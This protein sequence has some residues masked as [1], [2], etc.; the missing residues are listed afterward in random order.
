MRRAFA[1]RLQ[2]DYSPWMN[3]DRP[4]FI[5]RVS[6]S[7]SGPRHASGS[8]IFP[9][10]SFTKTVIS[11][12]ALRMV[13]EGRLDL[14]RPLDGY[15]ISLRQLLSHTSGL[16]DYHSL[17]AYRTAVA[18]NE[19]PWP[20]EDLREA[21]LAQGRLFP[22]GKGWAYSNLGYMMAR[23]RIE[24][25]AGQ[26]FADLVRQMICAPLGLDSIRLA[27]SRSDFARLH[28]AGAQHYHP[29]WVYHGCLTGT[30]AD[31]AE[32]LHAVFMGRVLHASMLTEMLI[33]HPLGGA[34]EGRPWTE[35]GYA[36][37]LMRGRCGDIGQMI[38]H[39]G[40]G[41]FCVN[42]IYHFPDRTVPTTIASFTDGPHQGVA[43]FAA[44]EAAR[45]T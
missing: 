27:T 10:W 38:G 7:E 35:C 4:I 2:E 1:E 40:G 16:P 42:A 13:Q 44:V 30:A 24:Q 6:R 34:I 25:V 32:L 26:P 23:D 39:S 19:E 18:Q 45:N 22:P 36:L 17:P 43:E 37:G 21:T 31:A 12:C 9:Y 11:I 33:H 28:W 29:G 15:D 8:E 5:H 14:D 3:T 41:P 20:A